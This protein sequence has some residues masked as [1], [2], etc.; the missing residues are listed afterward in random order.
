MEVEKFLKW[1]RLVFDGQAIYVDPDA[2]DWMAPNPAGDRLLTGIQQTRSVADGVSA[3]LGTL[4][5]QKNIGLIR[6]RQFLSLFPEPRPGL[7]PG[8]NRVLSLDRLKECWFHITDECNL[9]C[10]HCLFAND[11]LRQ[12]TLGFDDLARSVGEAFGLGA[13]TFYLTG[14]EPLMHP[15][16]DDICQLIL[17][18]SGDTHLVVLTNGLLLS[19]HR[20]LFA[21][22]PLDRLHFQISID[23]TQSTH[24][25]YRGTGAFDRLMDALGFVSGTK[26]HVTLAMAVTNDNVGQMPDIVQIAADHDI[27]EVHYLWL[28]AAGNATLGMMP[29]PATIFQ[30]L[31]AAEAYARQKDVTIDNIRQLESQIFSLP[32]TR[33]DLGG[34][35]WESLAIGP[36]GSVYPTPALVGQQAARCGHIRDSLTAVWQTGPALSQIRALTIADAP[37]YAQNPLRYL[38][39]GGDMDHSFYAGGAYV[40]HDP[41]VPLYNRMALWLMA[42]SAGS[43]T[44]DMGT[45]APFPQIRI[46]M[47]DRVLQ[48]DHNNTGVAL[49]HSNCVLTLASARQKVGQFYGQAAADPNPDIKNPVCYPETEISHI[50]ASARIRSYGCGSPVLD[51]ALKAGETLVDL[52]SGAGMECFIG[53][54][55]VGKTGYVFGI[56]M[57]DPM[58]ERAGKSL[59]AVSRHL[60]YANVAFKKGYL[61][62]LP[63]PDH[64]AD[65]VISNCVINLS[66]DKRKTFSEIFRILKPGGR[67]MISDVVTDTP[68]PPDILN[69]EQLRGECIAGAFVQPYLAAMLEAVGFWDIQFVK[70]FFY[71][72]VNGHRFYSLTY[73]A[74]KPDETKDVSVVYP[75][76]F[77]AVVTDSGKLLVRGHTGTLDAATADRCGDRVFVLD[78]LGNAANIKAQNACACFAP[79]AQNLKSSPQNLTI[80]LSLSPAPR[81]SAQC[82]VC[83]S[84]L[85]YLENNAPKSC[86]YC[87]IVKSANT[88][89]E[90]GHFVCDACHS[91]DALEMIRHV[92]ITSRQTD[93]IDLLN[94]IR[95]HPAMP[96]HG[97]EHH[98][99]VPGVIV[100]V[101]RNLGGDVSDADIAT[102][103]ERG[104][105][106]PGGVCAFWGSCGAALGAGVGFAVILKGNP[107]KPGERNAVQEATATI[108]RAI[109]AIEAARCCQRETWTALKTAAD[110]SRRLLPIPLRAE[111]R[112][113]CSQQAK[114]KECLGKGCPYIR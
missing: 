20:E 43:E 48:C 70:R 51:A 30:H 92:C 73:T 81:F 45:S 89:C 66:E 34:A 49:T 97:P 8:R 99:A 106:I 60:G 88:V 84:P 50:P 68:P 39:G 5:G 15:Q 108:S 96:L 4:N 24:D 6:A 27:P 25:L 22:I 105:A 80:G 12:K 87:G 46:K 71:R 57:L 98:F 58:L 32:G 17:N 114:N 26:V 11:H 102:A 52:G 38:V 56:D 55:Q 76:P 74:F 54:R 85:S 14:G 101:Y 94:T 62:N 83:G 7:Y 42:R 59:E 91:R 13:R 53:A 64:T 37:D 112:T 3:F 1:E 78:D 104:H 35:G 75:G 31:T 16:F 10:R 95:S 109:N 61:E 82:M 67:I 23:G 44:P 111:G 65:V 41:Y 9:R 69:D 33:Y 79:P 77:A 72:E 100:S 47:G 29:D 86:A 110:L 2:P 103:I 36:D 19:R 93:M 63:L 90:Q 113:T 18:M 21:Q 28:F 40:G 107:L